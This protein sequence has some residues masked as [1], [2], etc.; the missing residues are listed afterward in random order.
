MGWAIAAMTLY[1]AGFASLTIRKT[2]GSLRGIV[3]IQD[4]SIISLTIGALIIPVFIATS[5]WA[6]INMPWYYSLL[7]IF[8]AMLQPLSISPMND[9][10]RDGEI[11]FLLKIGTIAATFSLVGCILLWTGLV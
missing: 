1:T 5:I 3:A 8:I 6:F 7:W 2:R 10:L 9:L 11:E 4:K